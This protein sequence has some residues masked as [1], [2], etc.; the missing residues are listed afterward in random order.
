MNKVFASLLIMVY[1][2]SCDKDNDNINIPVISVPT[3]KLNTTYEVNITEDITY[4]EG[5]SHDSWNSANTSVVSLLMDSYVPDNDLQN[6]PLLMLIHGGGFSGG[7]KQQEVLVDMS[8][9]YASRGFVVFSI[10]YRLRGDM[11]TIPQEWIDVTTNVEPAELGQLLALYP[12]HRDAK[13]ALRWIIANAD[14]Y[15]ID[16]DYITV[17]GGSAGA[18]TSIGLGV[19]ELG[20]YKDE[21]S[22]SEDNTLSTTNLSTTYE[23]QTILDFWGSKV[24]LEILESIYGHQRFD[25]NDPAMFIAHGTEDTTV[26]FSSAGDL[27]TICE[28]NEVDFIYYPLEGRGHGPWGATVNGKSLS[29]LSFDFIVDNQ[30][31]N[32]E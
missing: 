6:R 30:N 13:A 19:S 10:D 7:S 5:L 29:D 23:V 22:L 12:A 16:T 20:D 11:G 21:I 27:K 1:L 17:G 24:S 2:I 26:P 32:V 14:N 31:L 15:H 28:T 8:N 18:I 9:Y 3:V 4:A 25:S